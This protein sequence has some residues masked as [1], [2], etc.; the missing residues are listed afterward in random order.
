MSGYAEWLASKA[1]THWTTWTFP[2]P[3][4]D[5]N[6]LGFTGMGTQGALKAYQRFWQMCLWGKV[7]PE[8]SYSL[9]AIEPHKSGAKHLHSLVGSETGSGRVIEYLLPK[10]WSYVGGGF[11]R[12]QAYNGSPGVHEY[13]SKYAIKDDCLHF[14]GR[15]AEPSSNDDASIA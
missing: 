15:W 3:R 11:C 9:V 13:C 12:I 5:G 4:G 10:L 14:F 7:I 8:T 1:W 6:R 2:I